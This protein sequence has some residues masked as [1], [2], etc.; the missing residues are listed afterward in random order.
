MKKWMHLV[1]L[2]SLSACSTAYKPGNSLYGRR[3]QKAYVDGCLGKAKE[4]YTALGRLDLVKLVEKRC[5]NDLK[6]YKQ[7]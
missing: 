7:E 6:N 1:I 4:V 5:L 2:V 3:V